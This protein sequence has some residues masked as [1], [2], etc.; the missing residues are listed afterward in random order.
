MKINEMQK[1]TTNKARSIFYIITISGLLSLTSFVI[2][3]IW[4]N[5]IIQIIE[6]SEISFLEAVGIVAFVYV[7]YFGIQYGTENCKNDTKYANMTDNTEPSDK[8]SE[9]DNEFV[10]N[11]LKTI[12]K[13][14]RR[15]L[16]DF[17][18]SCIEKDSKDESLHDSVH[19]N[20]SIKEK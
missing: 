10:K 9:K 17:L 20:L 1:T 11:I 13:S 12:P 14:E 6:I 2:L 7:I 8:L 5:S 3:L 19:A 16:K 4:N 18:A 15:K